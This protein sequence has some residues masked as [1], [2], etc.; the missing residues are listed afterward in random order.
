MFRPLA[1]L[2]LAPVASVQRKIAR[3]IFLAVLLV[4]TATG[5]AAQTAPAERLTAYR[6][7]LDAFRKEYGGGEWGQLLNLDAGGLGP[8]EVGGWPG[9]FDSNTP[10]DRGM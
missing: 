2:T 3:A 1:I 6:A 9:P 4:A 10:K 5:A 8:G 7:E